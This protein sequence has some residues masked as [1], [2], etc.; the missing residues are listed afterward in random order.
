MSNDILA[1]MKEEAKKA[2][3]TGEVSFVIGWGPTRFEDK[4]R[5]YFAKTEED[6][7]NFVWNKY[8]VNGL[9]KYALDDR[10]PEKKV[11][12]F[13]RGC[14]SRAINRMIRDKALKRE[15]LYLIGVVCDGKDNPICEECQHKNPLT[16]DVLIGEPTEETLHPERVKEVEEF[17]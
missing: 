4:T 15:N 1:L 10:F 5:P 7:D 8:C 9:A 11:A 2:L 16:Y 14:D 13:V 12:L 6:C 3:A 17:A